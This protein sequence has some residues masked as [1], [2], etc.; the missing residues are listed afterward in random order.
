M[1]RK[2]GEACEMSEESDTAEPLKPDE[3]V[4][5][6]DGVCN[7][8]NSSVN[9]IIDRDPKGYFKFASLQSDEAQRYLGDGGSTASPLASIVLVEG[10]RYYR[11][12]TAALRIARRLNGGWPLLYGLIGIPAP[13]RDAVYE[14]IARNRYTWFG[15][16]D[17][18]R[19]PT[20]DVQSRFLGG[21][22]PRYEV[23]RA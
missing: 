22:S 3:A 10:G 18:C 21:G 12:S 8:C 7:L 5:L 14:W 19:I 4:V 23:P 15:K 6:F 13:I 2:T 11:R 1:D 9:F 16:E 17:A 20:P